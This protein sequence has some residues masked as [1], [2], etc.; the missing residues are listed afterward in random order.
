MTYELSPWSLKDLYPGVSSPEL[1]AAFRQLDDH[2]SSFEKIRTQLKP[3][4]PASTF[5]EVVQDL[6]EGVCL[7]NKL[8][9]FPELAFAADTQ[10]Q[11]VQALLGRVQQF[12]AEMENRTLFLIS[13]GRIWMIRMPNDYWQP[14]EIINTI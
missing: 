1:E 11:E 3:D 7:A 8:Y 13:G 12:M 10:D 4:L 9:A 2:I 14:V 5:L 6:D